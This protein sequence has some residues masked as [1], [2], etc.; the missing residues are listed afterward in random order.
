VVGPILNETAARLCNRRKVAY[1][2]GC[3][4]ASEISYAEELGVE[5]VKIF[6]GSSVGGPGFVKSVLGPCPWTRIMPTG[7][8]DA[9]W[10]SIQAW[11]DAGVACVGM[12]SKLIRKD[13][14]A[15]GDWEEIARQVRQVL[16]WIKEARHEPLF[17]GVEHAG[18]YP[19]PEASGQAIG[20]WY[21]E[22]FGFELKEGKSS[23]FVSGPGNGRI[24]IMKEAIT[25]RCHIAVRVSNFE[26]AVAALE[27]QGV[28][29][30]EP[31]IKPAVKAVFLKDKDPAGNLVHLLWSD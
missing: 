22:R 2:P 27:A 9:T 15:A 6:P 11:L 18:L 4:S 19:T 23:F 7:G 25:D 29:L 8:V 3:G 10:E 31:K 13:L 17:L 16:D 12:G 26:K 20:E 28:R 1:M 21:K 14:V 24:E 5:I 30:E